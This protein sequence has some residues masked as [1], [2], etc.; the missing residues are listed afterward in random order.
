MFTAYRKEAEYE[1]SNPYK[2]KE[3][4]TYIKISPLS[5]LDI[6]RN[7]GFI[8]D[9]VLWFFQFYKE[10]DK[11]HLSQYFGVMDID[12]ARDEGSTEIEY[13]KKKDDYLPVLIGNLAIMNYDSYMIYKSGRKGYHVFI[14]SHEFWL[15]PP[16]TVNKHLRGQWIEEQVRRLFP[17]MWQSLDMSIYHIGK[18][19][20]NPNYPHP[21][22][23][24]LSKLI[25]T[26]NAP[27]NMWYYIADMVSSNQPTVVELTNIHNNIISPSV[28]NNTHTN[29]TL[30]FAKEN[31]MTELIS[32]FNGGCTFKESNRS[33]NIFITD[34]KYCPYKKSEH[35]SNKCYVTIND[36]IA[37]IYCHSE[38]CKLK[39]KEILE[40]REGCRPLTDFAYILNTL[41]EK[42]E[43]KNIID[44]NKIRRINPKDQ[45]Y[46]LPEDIRWSLTEN[47]GIISGAMSIGKT[48]AV[49]NYIMEETP[50][51]I[52]GPFKTLL[53]VTRIT[54][55]INFK[56]VYPGMISYLD[57]DEI[58]DKNTVVV[59]INSLSKV[60]DH[61][62]KTFPQYDLLIVDEVE[63]IIEGLISTM[64]SGSKSKQCNIWKLFK[65]LLW[66]SSNVLFMDGIM[67][68][69]TAM[70]LERLN[71]L[72]GCYL[73]QHEAQP[74]YRTYINYVNGDNFNEVFIEDCKNGK[75]VCLV[76]NCKN[77]LY[78][79][80]KMSCVD[81]DNRLTISGDSSKEEKLTSA[82]PNIEWTKDLLAFNTAVGPGASYNVLH[83]EIMYVVISPFSC[84]PYSTYQMINRIRK[85]TSGNVRMFI[86]HSE[87]KPV[88]SKEELKLSK[89]VNISSFQER[90][91]TFPMDIYCRMDGDYYKIDINTIDHSLL[92]KYVKEK[93]LVVDHE[94]N[95][96]IDTLVDY[97][98]EKL[99]FNSRE[100]YK[101][102]LFE[103]IERNG[104][105]I[106]GMKNDTESS[107][108]V[109]KQ[110]SASH[111]K[112]A[113][114][115]YSELAVDSKNTL[116]KR[117]SPI[118]DRDIINRY[119]QLNDI[120]V[121]IRWSS[122]RCALTKNDMSLYEKELLDINQQK[123]AISNILLFSNGL[124][125]FIKEL[126]ER[127]GFRI[128]Y[129]LGTIEGEGS[130]GEYFIDKQ[131]RIQESMDKISEKLLFSR[132]TPICFKILKGSQRRKNTAVCKNLELLLSIFGI[133]LIIEQE[134]QKRHHNADKTRY[135]D[136]HYSICLYS[137]YIRMAFNGIAFDTGKWIEDPW[138]HLLDNYKKSN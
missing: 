92:K 134:C 32:I 75:K 89:S 131:E 47:Y 122:L 55:A 137:Q 104:G 138:K 44:E 94:D 73:V 60:I 128:N 110:T 11:D 43:I 117:I 69:R 118:M 120:D 53:I 96:F 29:T 136:K 65:T 95:T 28:R 102:T 19:I 4:I 68:S 79:Y 106:V 36:K 8:Y 5:A 80:V 13:K 40:I 90:G 67:T 48:T 33:K 46:I 88:P 66:T 3:S 64:L 22:T 83:Y 52:D 130:F 70:F 98:H 87:T 2:N 31:I 82:D 21:K 129:I 58:H 25:V 41:K 42:G 71:I 14:F 59:C 108:K 17:C 39:Y 135:E 123:K 38:I 132:K 112:S 126:C 100:H 76:S 114:Q 63:A 16:S 45:Q 119:V 10:D 23:G 54:Q 37:R 18:G 51:K 9:A 74:D 35:K 1:T 127:V 15:M 113:K 115:N 105:K 109:L 26:R 27:Q 57:V 116:T 103:I 7:V 97:E 81:S 78:K 121:H 86:L 133:T 49:V 85:L 6:T 93:H 61:E 107:N 30:L 111:R 12:I 84:T 125:E 101:N 124:L 62:K 72:K 77:S 24:M 99:R 34:T 91:N 50:K 56:G 20:R